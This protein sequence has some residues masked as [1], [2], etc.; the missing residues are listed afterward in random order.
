MFHGVCT[1]TLLSYYKL[2][3]RQPHT[4][5]LACVVEALSSVLELMASPVTH[6]MLQYSRIS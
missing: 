3:G 6:S 4:W 1:L 2:S 5:S